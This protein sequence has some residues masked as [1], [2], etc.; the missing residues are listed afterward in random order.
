MGAPQRKGWKIEEDPIYGCW[1]WSGQVDR[2]GYGILWGKGG[3][4]RAHV[5]VYRELVGEPGAGMKLDHICRRR[6]CVRP[7]HLEPVTESVNQ[8]RRGW[9]CR[10]RQQRCRNGHDLRVHAM[11]TFE[12]GRLCRIC[13]GPPKYEGAAR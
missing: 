1:L 13:Q 9:G 6:R 8:Q 11:I 5:E 4:R 7:D 3:P 10:A 12:G 2:D